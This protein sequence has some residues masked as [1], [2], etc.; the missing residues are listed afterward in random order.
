MTNFHSSADTRCGLSPRA[1]ARVGCEA[2]T[3]VS[4]CLLC[5]ALQWANAR[6]KGRISDRAQKIM[7]SRISRYW[8]QPIWGK[9]PAFFSPGNPLSDSFRSFLGRG[10]LFGPWRR[11]GVSQDKS[12]VA[13][14]W[15]ARCSE[16]CGMSDLK[17]KSQ[18]S[19]AELSES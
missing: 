3:G 1:H 5:R 11:P 6:H 2:S 14:G 18:E 9:A 13:R 7:T 15:Q 10:A 17:L 4:C 16:P 19:S 12:Q 8:P